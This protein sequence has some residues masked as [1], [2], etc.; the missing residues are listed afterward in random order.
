MGIQFQYGEPDLELAQCDGRILLAPKNST[1]PLLDIEDA[2]NGGIDL[3]KVGNGSSFVKVGTYEKRAGVK[4]SNKPT[5]NDIKSSGYG[6]PTRKLASE[7]AKGITYTP[8]QTN[9]LN[10]QNSW[11]FTPSAVSDVSTKGGFT[12]GIPELPA[13]T[14]WRCAYIAWDSFEGEDVFMYWLANDSE[15]GDR[16]D[17]NAVDSNVYEYGVSLSFNT[18]PAVGLPVI[19]GMCGAGVPLLAAAVSDGALYK[20]AESV[21]VAPTTKSLTAA[22]GVNH[23]QQLTVTDSNGIDRTAMASYLSSDITKFTVSATGLMTGV[24]AGTGL[25]CT[26]TYMGLQATCAVTVT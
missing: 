8:Q 17:I 13:R 2:I 19:F 21:T 6:S 25:T 7:A 24:A 5:I 10:L 16:E 26:A 12:I 1:N 9:L 3:A 4:L 20:P 14:K 18:D 11:G 23:T 15:V 22:A